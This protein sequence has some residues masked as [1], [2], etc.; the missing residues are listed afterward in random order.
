M[1]VWVL[2]SAIMLVAMCEKSGLENLH[3]V[4]HSGVFHLNDL[5]HKFAGHRQIRR[6]PKIL[7]PAA[8]ADASVTTLANFSP[9]GTIVIPFMPRIVSN[10]IIASE[11]VKGLSV[12]SLTVSVAG[13]D[14]APLLA[15]QQ[16]ASHKVRV[17]IQQLLHRNRWKGG[18]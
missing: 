1:R 11:R 3:H 16:R 6:F 9:I 15:R 5:R 2:G 10:A 4:L 14:S 18:S 7:P 13:M 12:F 8:P 17:N